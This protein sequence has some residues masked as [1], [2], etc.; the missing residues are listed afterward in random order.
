[1]KKYL[2]A[3][4]LRHLL[5]VSLILPLG[6]AAAAENRGLFWQVEKDGKLVYLLGAVHFANSELYPLSPKIM[7][8][9]EKSD[10]L[11][12]EVDEQRVSLEKQQE[13]IQRYGFYPNGETLHDHLQPA[14]LAQIETL[15][16][17]FKLPLEQVAAYRPGMLAITLTTLQ[18]SKLG[19]TAEQGIDRYFMQ[20]ARYKKPIRQIENFESQMQLI[21]ALP[22]DD[23][24]VR[25]S[26]GEMSDYESTW[27]NTMAAWKKGD[28]VALYALAIGDALRDYPSLRAFFE[29]LFFSRHEAMVAS[30]ED[31]FARD[32]RCFVVVGAGHY[33]GPRG[34]V[35]ELE[36]LGYRVEQK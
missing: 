9:Y 16:N 24:S 5:L 10:V 15:L 32:E 22:E 25:D 36:K 4:P 7:A 1:M 19:Y 34:I 2:R 8:A 11:L 18:A 29:T 30:I 13:L 6:F 3:A 17:D 26:F 12:V 35:A 23:R 33:V 28:A 21:A 20:K 27:R 14:T 31:C